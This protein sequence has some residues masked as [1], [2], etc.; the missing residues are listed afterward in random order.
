MF[1]LTTADVALTEDDG[2]LKGVNIHLD[3]DDYQ[4]D[5]MKRSI[6]N[7]N[8]FSIVRM[9]PPRTKIRYY[10]SFALERTILATPPPSKESKN[11]YQKPKKSKYKRKLD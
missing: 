11:K 10:F 6:K 7:P 1:D 2:T 3:F 8:L 5:V 9:V 4:P